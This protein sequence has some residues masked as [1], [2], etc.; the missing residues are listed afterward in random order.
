MR[1]LDFSRFREEPRSEFVES[2]YAKISQED[3]R[4]VRIRSMLQNPSSRPKLAIALV[5]AILML[6]ACARQVFAPRNVQVGEFW[7]HEM[8]E[9]GACSE[10][11]VYPSYTPS[12]P[13]PT[14]QSQ[15]KPPPRV[16]LEEFRALLDFELAIPN[17][18]PDG[19]SLQEDFPPPTLSGFH[20]INWIAPDGTYI[21]MWTFTRENWPTGRELRVPRGTWEEIQVRGTPA[22][23]VRGRCGVVGDPQPAELNSDPEIAWSDDITRLN[24]SQAGV[25]YELY[26][27]DIEIDV[28]V[29]MAESSR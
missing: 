5:A 12:S 17:Q 14:P 22:V 25:F 19:Y 10:N 4:I 20:N 1:E 23:V 2:L 7:V 9:K 8:S 11:V 29:A 3:R 21:S 28:L 26:A 18:P 27:R 13:L 16:S 15:P 6:G 24:W